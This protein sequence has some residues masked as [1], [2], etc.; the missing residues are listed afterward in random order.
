MFEQ[1][2]VLRNTTAKTAMKTGTKIDYCTA[3]NKVASTAFE[4]FMNGKKAVHPRRLK[5]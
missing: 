1:A 2:N 4:N 5:K 3:G